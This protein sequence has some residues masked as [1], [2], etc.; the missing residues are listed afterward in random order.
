MQLAGWSKFCCLEVFVPNVQFGLAQSR[1]DV[2]HFW[3]NLF[4]LVRTCTTIINSW[5]AASDWYRP[6]HGTSHPCECYGKDISRPVKK[7]YY[8]EFWV[9]CRL[10]GWRMVK[11]RCRQLYP[12]LTAEYFLSASRNPVQVFYKCCLHDVTS[13]CLSLQCLKCIVTDVVALLIM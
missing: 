10:F 9:A 1:H 11:N 4:V 5:L 6:N 13:I 7:G 2:S 8:H 12:R 3:S